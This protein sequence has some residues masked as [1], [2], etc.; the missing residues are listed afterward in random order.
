MR[1]HF[2]VRS[3]FVRKRFLDALVFVP[4]ESVLYKVF[5]FM[6]NKPVT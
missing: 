2:Y 5:L 4:L 3:K 6:N 1:S